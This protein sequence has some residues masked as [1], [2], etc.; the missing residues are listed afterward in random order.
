MLISNVGSI[1]SFGGGTGTSASLTLLHQK[2]NPA[3]GY[4]ISPTLSPVLDPSTNRYVIQFDNVV[5]SSLAQY[6]T[7]FGFNGSTAGFSIRDDGG[8]T[9][10]TL[11]FN[12]GT[13]AFETN[14]SGYGGPAQLFIPTIGEARRIEVEYGLGVLNVILNG[15]PAITRP[16][17]PGTYATLRYIRHSNKTHPLGMTT[18][19]YSS[20]FTVG[21]FRVYRRELANINQLVLLG[22]SITQSTNYEGFLKAVLG[23]HWFIQNHGMGYR[24]SREL[25]GAL[26]TPYGGDVHNPS[27]HTTDIG[28]LYNSS[29]RSNWVLIGIGTN[30]CLWYNAATQV[31]GPEAGGYLPTSNGSGGALDTVANILSAITTIK[32]NNPGWKVAVRTMPNLYSQSGGGSITGANSVLSRTTTLNAAI[33]TGVIAA[34]ADLVID[35][36]NVFAPTASR[37]DGVAYNG[38]L[39]NASYWPYYSQNPLTFDG[40][41]IHPTLI[42]YQAISQYI[43][44]KLLA[45]A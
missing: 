17:N 29:M 25:L 7:C 32:A 23:D 2:L 40:F 31:A 16:L 35:I 9:R 38:S 18:C 36:D 19:N 33:R 3:N 12:D 11:Y 37:T 13:G 34:A 5:A 26:S 30:D 27:M 42:G 24:Q 4:V 45:V 14:G 15:V 44:S 21:A 20:A 43:A 41:H 6:D 8:G 28:G 10:E 39:Y 1:S 22:D